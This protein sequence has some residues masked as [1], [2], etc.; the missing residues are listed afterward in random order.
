MCREDHNQN[1]K[2]AY[3]LHQAEEHINQ[4]RLYKY[5]KPTKSWAN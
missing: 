5:Y 3:P 2:V 4:D 1:K